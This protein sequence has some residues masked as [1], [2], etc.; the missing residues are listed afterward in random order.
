MTAL[1]ILTTIAVATMDLLFFAFV[2][3]IVLMLIGRAVMGDDLDHW[4]MG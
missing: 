3:L 2:A 4:D 1:G